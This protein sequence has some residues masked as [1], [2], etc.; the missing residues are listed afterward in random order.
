[1]MGICHSCRLR[2][3]IDK[4]TKTCA[5]CKR[6]LRETADKYFDGDAFLPLKAAAVDLAR[7]KR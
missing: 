4:L 6:Q 7:A 2:T 3:R 5:P 1:M